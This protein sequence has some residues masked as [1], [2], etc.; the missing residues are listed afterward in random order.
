M[1]G[2]PIKPQKFAVRCNNVYFWGPAYSIMRRLD[3]GERR[4]IPGRGIGLRQA[5]DSLS[6]SHNRKLPGWGCI[7]PTLP[8][9]ALSKSHRRG[10]R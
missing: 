10:E 1:V 5:I 4:G 8:S 9:R 6:L 7:S 3:P 2:K